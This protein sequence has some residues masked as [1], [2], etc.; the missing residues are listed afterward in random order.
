MIKTKLIDAY[1]QKWLDAVFQ[2]SKFL[3]YRI[4]KSELI[5][6]QYLNLLPFDLATA[7]CHFRTLNHKLPIEYGRFCSSDRDDRVCELSLS[8]RLGDEFHYLFECSYFVDQQKAYIPKEL[9]KRPNV[10]SFEKLMNTKDLQ[11]LF[12]LGKFCKK[13]LATF[14]VIYSRA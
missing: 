7:L 8:D 1:K 2:S 4:F 10:V 9:L 12:K 6:E 5:Y 13:I 3:N 14:K 11:T